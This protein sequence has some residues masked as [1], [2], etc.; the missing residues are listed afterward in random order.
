MARFGN[1]TDVVDAIGVALDI[2]IKRQPAKRGGD[3]SLLEDQSHR[4]ATARDYMPGRRPV[5]TA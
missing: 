3:D 1:P 2:S 4:R 5:R